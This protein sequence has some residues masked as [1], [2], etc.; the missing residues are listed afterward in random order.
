[1]I[2]PKPVPCPVCGEHPSFELYER[3]GRCSIWC[4]GN[5]ERFK[6]ELTVILTHEFYVGGFPTAAIAEWNR[7]FGGEK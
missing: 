1:M 4:G 3:T 2:D 6:D 7:R 5:K